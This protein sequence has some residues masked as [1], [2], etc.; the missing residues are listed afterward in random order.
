MRSIRISAI[1]VK[2]GTV[3]HYAEKAA[4]PVRRDHIQQR[5]V[6]VREHPHAQWN[7]T[8]PYRTCFEAM[9]GG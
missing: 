9:V 7:S 3:E 8:R 6:F 2:V 5:A 1:R 4:I